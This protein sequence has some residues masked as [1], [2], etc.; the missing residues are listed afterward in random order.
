MRDLLAHVDSRHPGLISAFGGHAMAAGLTLPA[1]GL[2]R[3]ETALEESARQFLGEDTLQAEVLTD[4]ELQ[5]GEIGLDLAL[6]LRDCG[7]WGQRFP[8]PVFEGAFEVLDQ[9]IVGG[10]HL[11]LLLRPLDGHD[12]VDAIA[13]RTLPEDLPAGNALRALYRLDVNHFRG[14]RTCQLV[15][16]HLVAHGPA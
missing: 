10:A 4:G 2:A 16:E 13:F 3:F 9:R 1:A 8:E 14:E 12:P 5:A 6:A 7:P 15:I 11:K